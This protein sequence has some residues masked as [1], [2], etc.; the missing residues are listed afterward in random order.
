M[1]KD[2][3]VTCPLVDWFKFHKCTLKT[4]KNFTIQTQHHCLEIDRKKPEGTKIISDAELNFYKLSDRQI[5]TRLVQIHRKNAV[6]D[7]KMILV[8]KAFIE[9]IEENFEGGGRFNK[10]EMLMAENTY[11]LNISR[12]GW[13]NWMWEYLLDEAVWRKFADR[14]GG[15]CAEFSVHQMLNIKLGKYEKLLAE[16]NS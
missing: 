4:C 16:F 14:T 7:V 12:L 6:L 5:S 10:P 3:P 9:Y 1:P 11:P 13:R 15:E 2:D 8:L